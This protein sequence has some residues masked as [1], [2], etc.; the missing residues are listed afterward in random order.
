MAN[1]VLM[2]LKGTSNCDLYTTP[3]YVKVGYLSPGETYTEY[4]IEYFSDKHYP[5]TDYFKV[6]SYT[7]VGWRATYAC[8]VRN[9]FK[10]EK[11]LAYGA[12]NAKR[13]ISSSQIIF[14]TRRQ[15]RVYNGTTLIETLPTGSEIRT[16]GTSTAGYS[17]PDRLYITGY[18]RAGATQWK[19]FS[20][21]TWAETG[22]KAGYYTWPSIKN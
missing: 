16:D 19:Y 9:L 20:S 14:E 1:P 7:T 13:V 6:A 10:A 4:G 11:E 8:P 22:I 15:V 21:N 12:S 17:Q 18:K 3:D 2:K 5:I